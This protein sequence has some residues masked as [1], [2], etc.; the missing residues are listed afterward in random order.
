M[1]QFESPRFGSIEVDEEQFIHFERGLPGFPG[2]HDFVVM[3]H[4]R[5]TPL[6][7][8]QS[9]DRPE[10]AFLIVEPAQVL[11]TYRVEIPPR[12][13]ASLAWDENHDA[14][15]DVAVFVILNAEGSTLTANLRAPV[16]VHMK[17]RRGHQMILDDPS[18]PL[19]HEI[20]PEPVP[21]SEE[22]KEPNPAAQ[23]RD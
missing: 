4:D 7:W 13:L 5:E 15:Q 9:V 2:C 11:S 20:A 22:P 3:E 21:Q 6:H 23:S 8:M 1:K 10:V 17:T 16:L 12:I 18:L 14:E 19:R